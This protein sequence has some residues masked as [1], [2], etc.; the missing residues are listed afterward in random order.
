MATV[1]GF[2]AARMLAMEAATIVNGA[3][4]G[5][6]HLILTKH[7]ASTVDAGAV[8][9][10][11]GAPGVS[12]AQLDTF[13]NDHL[14]V[15]ASVEYIGLTSPSVKWLL[16]TGQTIVNGQTL[17]PA[18]WAIIPAGMKSGSSIIMPDMRG[19]VIV[20]YDS[21]QTEFDAILET[22]GA[23]THTLTQ[24]QLPAVG[25]NIDPP[26]AP[27]YI[28]VPNTLVT[29]NTGAGTPHNH[30]SFDGG[31]FVGV[32]TGSGAFLAL[33]GGTPT[34]T[35][36]AHSHPAGALNC[37]PDPFWATADFAPYS[38]DNMGSGSAHNNLQPYII[39]QR[40]I[41]VA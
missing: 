12:Q 27:V 28:D 18:F 32:A 7:D 9:G 35:E 23:K 13:M 16:A 8:I 10:P 30:S 6:G 25:V 21:T 24:A 37:N 33:P 19:K 29:G 26:P 39:M 5:S 36:A 40:L 1:T 34:G 4:N 17:Y 20:A 3:V 41:K 22:G 38:S 31:T 2:T 14:P 11:T 15:G